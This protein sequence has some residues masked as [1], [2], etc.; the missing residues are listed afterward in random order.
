MWH[1]SKHFFW[2]KVKKTTNFTRKK[3]AKIDQKPAKNIKN[4]Q[5]QKSRFL[6]FLECATWLR[7][8]MQDSWELKKNV[9]ALFCPLWHDSH[10]QEMLS[11]WAWLPVV[12]ID[13]QKKSFGSFRIFLGQPVLDLMSTSDKT[14]RATLNEGLGL[15]VDM[16]SSATG[17][18]IDLQIAVPWLGMTGCLEENIYYRGQWYCLAP[19]L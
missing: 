8:P 19:Y 13:Y 17:D 14:S 16:K 18:A 5:I 1:W 2:D 4:P 15:A 3:P 11:S 12:S 9:R 6:G 10:T 7:N